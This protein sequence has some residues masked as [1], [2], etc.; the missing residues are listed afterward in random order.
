MILG[1][2]R[3]CHSDGVFKPQTTIGMGAKDASRPTISRTHAEAKHRRSRALSTKRDRS[4]SLECRVVSR[5][6]VAMEN[7]RRH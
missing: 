6:A 2:A 1:Q 5:R 7:N 3:K 4:R